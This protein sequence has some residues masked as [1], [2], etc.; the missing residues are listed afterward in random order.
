MK[1]GAFKY[2]YT[3]NEAA[4]VAAEKL[5]EPITAS[6]IIDKINYEELRAWFDGTGRYARKVYPACHYQPDTEQ[7][8]FARHGAMS[9]IFHG[10]EPILGMMGYYEIYTG[11]RSDMVI[12]EPIDETTA[13]ATWDGGYLL[14]DRDGSLLQ[15]VRRKKDA[16]IGS[17]APLDFAID[18]TTIP[19]EKIWIA[20]EDLR[21]LLEEESETTDSSPDLGTVERNTLHKLLT[22]MAIKGYGYE[23]GKA[24]QKR[25]VISNLQE[26][27]KSLGIT[28]TDDT[29]RKYLKEASE[30]FEPSKTGIESMAR[31]LTTFQR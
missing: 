6:D 11:Q 2:W 12:F 15:V 31:Q 17:R 5:G 22:V 3:V 9:Y 1:I 8:R 24:R 26:H 20:A 25:G 18:S 16:H 19:R 23:P 27:L 21:S 4:Q 29:I 30:T 13:K 14:V 10:D 28:L 7:N